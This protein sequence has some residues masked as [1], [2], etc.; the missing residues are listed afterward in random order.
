MT[1]WT[2]GVYR[3]TQILFSSLSFWRQG[4]LFLRLALNSYPAGD[5]LELLI[6]LT[7]SPKGW[8]GS[9]E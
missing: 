6:L 1:W 9:H 7:S 8:S 4:L 3:H 2:I 5:D